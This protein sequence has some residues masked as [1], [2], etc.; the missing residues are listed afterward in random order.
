MDIL[1]I[2]L[3]L[4]FSFMLYRTISAT[5]NTMNQNNPPEEAN[6]TNGINE[7]N[8]T[9][10]VN[11]PIVEDMQNTEEDLYWNKQSGEVFNDEFFNFKN[12][13]NNN[14]KCKYIPDNKTQENQKLSDIYDNLTKYE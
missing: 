7:A 6:G 3:F 9:N 4:T 10:E 14:S 1:E 13:I 5:V 8:G 2:I 12:R 11:S